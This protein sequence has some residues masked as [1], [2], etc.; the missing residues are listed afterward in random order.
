M[1]M[2]RADIHSLP[3]PL[4]RKVGMSVR[5]K[6]K[7]SLLYPQLITVSIKSFTLK[8]ERIYII[9]YLHDLHYKL[10]KLFT[11]YIN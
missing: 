11:F 5:D 8:K 9:N 10:I 3:G 7:S 1:E 6:S 4:K 2:D